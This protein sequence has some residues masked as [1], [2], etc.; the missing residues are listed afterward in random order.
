[1]ATM[2]NNKNSNNGNNQPL[3]WVHY[4]GPNFRSQVGARNAPYFP[5]DPQPQHHRRLRLSLL[6]P[7][8]DIEEMH[9]FRAQA[10]S[11]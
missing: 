7:L 3:Q 8:L 1:M 4:Q 9:Q 11:D 10:R 6:S 5:P 2:S